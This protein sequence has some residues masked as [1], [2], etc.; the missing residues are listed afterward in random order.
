MVAATFPAFLARERSDRQPE[1]RSIGE[2]ESGRH[3]A[4]DSVG[5]P[6]QGDGLIHDVCVAAEPL[7]PQR[8]TQDNHRRRPGLVLVVTE[9]AADCRSGPE[10]GEGVR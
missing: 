10:R 2:S 3:D 8:V 7:A 1:V 9:D 4:N 6:V 5:T